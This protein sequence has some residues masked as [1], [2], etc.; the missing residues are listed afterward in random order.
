MKYSAPFKGCTP[1]NISQGYKS[2][3]H[4]AL[5]IYKAGTN[6]GRGEPLTAP[7]DVR[8]LHIS[9]DQLTTGHS[10]LKNGFG[11]YM[12]GLESGNV[13]LYWHTFP[14]FPVT[15]G[16]VVKRGKIVAFM[17][18][19]GYVLSGGKYVPLE[20]RYTKDDGIHLHWEVLAQP[21]GIHLKK[22]FVRFDT[23]IDWNS[24]PTYNVL[25]QKIAILKTILRGYQLLQRA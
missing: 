10:A 25:E 11:I 4:P 7:E 9:G 5:D 24:Q 15:V 8:I 19:S 2:T 21:W 6:N 23:D 17:S 18:N 22:N 12:L 16:E 14:A 20:D 3:S 13:H 1:A